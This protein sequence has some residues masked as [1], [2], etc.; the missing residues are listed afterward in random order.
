MSFPEHV[1][2]CPHDLHRR[3]AK[4]FT[5]AFWLSTSTSAVLAQ[6]ARYHDSPPSNVPSSSRSRLLRASSESG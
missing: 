3:C 5:A 6:P 1:T 4:H 2:T